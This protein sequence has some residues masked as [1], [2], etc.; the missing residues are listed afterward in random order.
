[1]NSADRL[2][3]L[4]TAA[5]V[6]QANVQANANANQPKQKLLAL[7]PFARPCPPKE[8]IHIDDDRDDEKDKHIAQTTTWHPT[9]KAAYRQLIECLVTWSEMLHKSSN[10]AQLLASAK[11]IGLTTGLLTPLFDQH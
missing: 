9:Q 10:F 11:H 6:V 8:V 5:A 2:M 4:A 3:V 7:P 1:M